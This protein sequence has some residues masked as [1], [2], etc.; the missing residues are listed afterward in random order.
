MDNPFND[1]FN[2]DQHIQNDLDF[3][4]YE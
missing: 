3:N 1:F 2:P 4:S